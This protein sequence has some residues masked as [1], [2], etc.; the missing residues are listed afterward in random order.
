[1]TVC[2]LRLYSLTFTRKCGHMNVCHRTLGHKTVTGVA[3]LVRTVSVLLLLGGVAA[4]A[5]REAPQ[6]GEYRLAIQLPGGEVPMQVRIEKQH[7]VLQ[8]RVMDGRRSA[9][10]TDLKV[11]AG[12]LHALL[13]QS[14]GTLDADFDRNGMHGK[15]QRVSDDKFVVF[16]V[17]AVR[18]AHYRFIE[19][20]LT[21]NS[22]VSG[23]WRIHI[24]SASS[25]MS[26]SQR[27]DAVDGQ[28]Q[29]GTSCDIRGQVHDDDV[30]I[31]AFCKDQLWLLKGKVD[32]HGNLEGQA[33]RNNDPPLAWHAE[34][35]DASFNP[36][37]G[38]RE[39]VPPWAVPAR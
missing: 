22:D 37:A 23:N 9:T 21:D 19:K 5:R 2:S 10:A 33:W 35:V 34:H 27:H 29:P 6:L 17:T 39:A 30:Y 31:A 4:C 12:T 1:M 7:S 13:P 16:P 3:A 15:L 24:A 20:S 32:A 11:G 8:L 18:N 38:N 26:L 25:L 28:W 14:L 36:D